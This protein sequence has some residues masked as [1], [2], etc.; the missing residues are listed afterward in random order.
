MDI[1]TDLISNYWKTTIGH[2]EL[3][4]RMLKSSLTP[5]LR[6]KNALKEI[7]QLEKK[8]KEMKRTIKEV[9]NKSNEEVE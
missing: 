2:V 4:I 5:P 9:M 1:K 3:D 7:R 6:Y 8:L